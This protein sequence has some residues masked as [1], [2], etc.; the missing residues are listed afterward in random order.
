MFALGVI[1]GHA[2]D[3]HGFVVIAHAT[4]NAGLCVV[5]VAIHL[6]WKLASTPGEVLGF[7]CG[8]GWELGPAYSGCLREGSSR[9]HGRRIHQNGLARVKLKA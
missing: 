7:V 2:G 6:S 9:H 1:I 5:R 8:Q 4:P 3:R